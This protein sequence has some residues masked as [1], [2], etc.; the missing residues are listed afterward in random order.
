MV[1]L[2]IWMRTSPLLDNEEFVGLVAFSEDDTAG[3]EEARLD[4]V[5]R[6]YFKA[7]VMLHH[8]P[9]LTLL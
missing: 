5:A 8:C 2:P 1:R 6:Q 7:R 9:R 3:L 4:V